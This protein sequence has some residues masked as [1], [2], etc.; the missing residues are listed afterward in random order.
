MWGPQRPKF[1]GFWIL[2]ILDFGVWGFWILDLD[3]VT[4]FGFY[5][6]RRRLCTPIRVGGLTGS[7]WEDF[8]NENK[9]D[10]LCRIFAGHAHVR[11]CRSCPSVPP[12]GPVSLLENGNGK[13]IGSGRVIWNGCTTGIGNNSGNMCSCSSAANHWYLLMFMF[14]R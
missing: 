5:I 6:R 13:R 9:F 10:R 4:N 8:W 7:F 1:G 3:F 2:G 14:D 11:F 12:A